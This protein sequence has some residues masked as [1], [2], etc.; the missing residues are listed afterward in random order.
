MNER[1]EIDDKRELR[2]T[3]MKA[4]N[5]G[6]MFFFLLIIL[7]FIFTDGGNRLTIPLKLGL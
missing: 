4:M 6:Q 5:R 7:E 3:E 1:I 2:V